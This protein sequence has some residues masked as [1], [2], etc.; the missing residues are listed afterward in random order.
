M[1]IAPFI[2]DTSDV[3]ACASRA[4]RARFDKAS[5]AMQTGFENRSPGDFNFGGFDLCL[6]L[7]ISQGFHNKKTRI[8]RQLNSRVCARVCRHACIH[9]C[10][11]VPV[12]ERLCARVRLPS[13]LGFF[14]LFFLQ[15]AGTPCVTDALC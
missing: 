10:T 14:Q 5:R 2:L 12:R 9:V 7:K 1:F 6:R 13:K 3:F 11:R 4:T 15:D 8:R